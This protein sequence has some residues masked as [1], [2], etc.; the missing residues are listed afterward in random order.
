MELA[1]SS[2]ASNARL[3]LRS[4]GLGCKPSRAHPLLMLAVRAARENDPSVVGSLSV[5]FPSGVSLRAIAIARPDACLLG[6]LPP[7]ELAVVRE[8]VEGRSYEEIARRRGTSQRTIANQVATVFRRMQVSGRNEL[9]HSL[10]AESRV[11]AASARPSGLPLPTWSPL[12]M[13]AS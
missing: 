2:V 8:L 1:P 12:E 3:G 10:F 9:V 13:V 6:V 7:A 11:E 5:V 4:L